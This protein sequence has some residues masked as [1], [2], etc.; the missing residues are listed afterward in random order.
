MLLQNETTLDI[1]KS[2]QM[3]ELLKFYMNRLHQAVRDKK[4]QDIKEF[5][6][7]GADINGLDDEVCKKHILLF[8]CLNTV[9]FTCNSR[10]QTQKMHL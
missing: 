3:I 5:I 10:L 7:N 4:T 1:A 9:P 8:T 2:E 6:E